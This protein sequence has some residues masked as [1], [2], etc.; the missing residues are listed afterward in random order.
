MP[1]PSIR[2]SEVPD[3]STPARP[4]AELRQTGSPLGRRSLELIGNTP[5]LRLDRLTRDL[6]G[7]QLLG[8]AEWFNPGGSVKDRAASNIVAQA[9]ASGEFGPGKILLDST[10]GNTGIAYAMIGAA[11]GFPVTLCMPENV[12]MERK[13]ILHAYGANIIYTDPGD[14]SDGAIRAA[15]E[16][17]AREPDK[18]FYA[19]QYSN[20]ANWQ[21]HYHGTAQE[22]WQQTEGRVT[23]FIAMLG[24]SG[25]FMGTSRRLKE[26]NPNIRCIS[27]QPDSPFHGI[28][29]AKHMASA[30]VPKIYDPKLADEDIEIATEDAYTNAVR[31]A[32][33][34]GL[35]LGIS[36]GAAIAGSLQIARRL[37]KQE[38]AVIVTIFPDSG[39]KYL[40]E[41]FWTEASS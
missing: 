6:P 3:S 21:A 25:T 20:D 23:H 30:I 41:R 15:R 33:E 16:L 29:G 11:E 13:H 4:E 35:L 36:A 32:R 7:V 8:K 5:L 37:G 10:S 38:E 40:S 17:F 31:G 24:T 18:Y 1:R 14:G 9:R 26:L 22:I 39:D 28:E 19:D 34:E 27:L 12:S 2:R